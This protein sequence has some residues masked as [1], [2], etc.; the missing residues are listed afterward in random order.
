MKEIK[1]KLIEAIKQQLDDS[2]SNKEAP[3]EA[4][5]DAINT[6]INLHYLG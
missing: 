1:D 2:I 3:S 4:T 6:L 5:L